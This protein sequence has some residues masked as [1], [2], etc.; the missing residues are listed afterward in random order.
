MGM[1]MVIPANYGISI[2][3][4]KTRGHNKKLF[5]DH[6]TIDARRFYFG[7]R[8]IKPWNSLSNKVVNE[9]STESFKTLVK[10]VIYLPF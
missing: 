5:A 2:P 3:K 8:V 4:S 7:C 9:P 1:W 6:T 10:S